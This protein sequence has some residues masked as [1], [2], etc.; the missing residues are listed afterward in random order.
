MSNTTGQIIDLNF[1]KKNISADTLIAV[2]GCQSIAH[3]DIDVQKMNCD[4]FLSLLIK[5]MDHLVLEFYMVRK[6]Y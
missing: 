6:V 1:I 4:F 2:D 3:C 5:F